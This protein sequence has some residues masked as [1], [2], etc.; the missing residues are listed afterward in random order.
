MSIFARCC[1]CFGNK[2]IEAH[3]P[4]INIGIR[5]LQENALEQQIEPP[6][7]F[8]ETK[9]KLED[10]RLSEFTPANTQ[11]ANYSYNCPICL[12]YFSTI[13]MLNCCKNYICHFCIEELKSTIKFEIACPHC[14]S[15]PV[16][17]SDVDLGSTVKKYSD[18]PYG[19][20]KPNQNNPGNKW[21]PMNIVK[22]DLE[23]EESQQ[24]GNLKLTVP[25][26]FEVTLNTRMHQTA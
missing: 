23:L 12:R 3:S 4:S 15:I 8:V 20:F 7:V 19:T 16:K 21:V 25:E 26:N 9:F 1:K 13:L 11:K 10:V 6:K 18:S 17:A 14:K 22:E 2:D 5:G 24:L